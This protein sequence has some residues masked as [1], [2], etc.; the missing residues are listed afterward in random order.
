MSLFVVAHSFRESDLICETTALRLSNCGKLFAV[1]I[2]R[3][4]VWT[5]PREVNIDF[6]LAE[7]RHHEDD[8]HN[9]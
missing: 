3:V 2:G 1:S 8:R 4:I 9:V 6:T 5:Y 7:F